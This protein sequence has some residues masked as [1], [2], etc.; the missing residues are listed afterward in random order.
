M[1]YILIVSEPAI[2]LE[3]TAVAAFGRAVSLYQVLLVY[4]MWREMLILVLV[5]KYE[6]EYV[7]R[8]FTQENECYC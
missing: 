4:D 7:V 6:Y 1:Q 8:N 3:C 5:L 2:R